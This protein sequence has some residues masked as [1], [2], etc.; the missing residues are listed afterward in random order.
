MVV[1]HI[2]VCTWEIKHHAV[3]ACWNSKLKYA[4]LP[5]SSQTCD[6]KQP[7]GPRIFLRLL[8]WLLLRCSLTWNWGSKMVEFICRCLGNA[9]NAWWNSMS[10]HACIFSTGN[11]DLKT[12]LQSCWLI[13]PPLTTWATRSDLK[14]MW[15][16]V[17]MHSLKASSLGIWVSPRRKLWKL[18]GKQKRVKSSAKAC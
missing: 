15:R 11:S 12:S 16:Y 14:K 1:E 6:Q 9:I 7:S 4:F 18:N 8:T 5:K 10:Q 17:S 3:N 2:I 13:A